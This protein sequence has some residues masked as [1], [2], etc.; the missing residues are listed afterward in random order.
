MTQNDN[1]GTWQI[2]PKDFPASGLFIDKLNFFIK[3]GSLAPS[4]HNSQP[5]SVSV[6]DETIE[7]KMNSSRLLEHA[8]PGNHYVYF[9]LGAFAANVQW[10][11]SYFGYSAMIEYVDNKVKISFKE[12]APDLGTDPKAITKRFSDKRKYMN[13]VVPEYIIDRINEYTK[14]FT[15]V[16]VLFTQSETVKNS[17]IYGHIKASEK[18]SKNQFFVTELTKSMKSN[19]T[20]SKFGMPGFVVGMSNIQSILIRKLLSKKPKLFQKLIIKE[21]DVLNNTQGFGLINISRIQVEE[22]VRAGIVYQLI[23]LV[24]SHYGVSNAPL[25]ALAFD[26]DSA[27]KLCHDLKLSGKIVLLFRFGYPVDS[28]PLHTP[29]EAI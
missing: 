23:S 9:A 28:K 11:S 2:E 4:V 8:D 22:M 13:K 18:L 10:C 27:G 21:R 16:G 25:T 6:V 17:I 19:T 7:L 5:W 26:D 29:R 20:K 12:C 24:F 15:D 1:Y 14:K 3:Y